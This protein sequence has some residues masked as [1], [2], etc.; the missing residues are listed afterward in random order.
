MYLYVLWKTSPAACARHL[1]FES[2]VQEKACET[3]QLVQKVLGASRTRRVVE[4]RPSAGCCVGLWARV[5][6]A[7]LGKLFP[8]NLDT[9]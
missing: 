5:V 2:T 8:R 1:R 9:R 3:Q 4:G 6:V 7:E